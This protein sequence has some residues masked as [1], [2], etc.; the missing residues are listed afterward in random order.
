M[1]CLLGGCY[2]KRSIQSH[3]HVQGLLVQD[4]RLIFMQASVFIAVFSPEEDTA[5]F[6][7]AAVFSGFSAFQ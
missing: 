6:S 7:G 2:T 5:L 4:M 1:R 3:A